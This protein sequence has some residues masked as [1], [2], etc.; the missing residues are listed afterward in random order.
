MRWLLRKLGY[1]YLLEVEDMDIQ[2]ASNY[3]FY[4]GLPLYWRDIKENPISLPIGIV[5]NLCAFALMWKIFF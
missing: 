1:F 5:M 2:W 4:Y 3:S